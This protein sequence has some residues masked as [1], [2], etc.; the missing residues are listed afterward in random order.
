MKFHYLDIICMEVYQ[1]GHMNGFLA[2]GIG[3]LN[4]N[5]QKKFKCAEGVPGGGARGGGGVEL[6]I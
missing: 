2:Q 1:V 5:F 3:N 6:S 4:T